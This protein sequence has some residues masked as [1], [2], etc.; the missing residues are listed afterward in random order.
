VD[1]ERLP[2]MDP[3]GFRFL[4]TT[5]ALHPLQSPHTYPML[6]RFACIH[7]YLADPHN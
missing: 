5:K 4:T 6:E 2:D 3:T 1:V 7:T